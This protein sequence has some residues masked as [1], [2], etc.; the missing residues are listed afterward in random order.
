MGTLKPTMSL[1]RGTLA[2]HLQL[3]ENFADSVDTG[4]TLSVEEETIT[5][6]DQPAVDW[7]QSSVLIRSYCIQL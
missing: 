7:Y 1:R 4:A 5:N 2:K 3:D 6:N